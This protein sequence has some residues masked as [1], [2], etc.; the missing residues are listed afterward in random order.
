MYISKL[1][2]QDLVI[3]GFNLY[4]FNNLVIKMYKF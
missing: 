3:K 1:I 4:N 2:N